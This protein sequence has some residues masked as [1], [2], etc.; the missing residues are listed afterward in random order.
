M[1][2]IPDQWKQIGVSGYPDPPQPGGDREYAATYPSFM[3]RRYNLQLSRLVDLGSAQVPRA[4]TRFVGQND[5]RY[6]S[7]ELDVLLNR[8]IVTVP[9]GEHNAVVGQIL[10]HISGNLVG[11]G[12]FYSAETTFLS[13]RLK[14]VIGNAQPSDFTYSHLW[15]LE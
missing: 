11:V 13:N 7:P 12:I 8:M 10:N 5:P 6:A 1:F 4:E 3:V 15:D 2:A 14:N 9:T